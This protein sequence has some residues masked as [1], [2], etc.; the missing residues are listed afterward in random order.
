MSITI[1]TN[2]ASISA[3]FR[4]VIFESTSNRFDVNPRAYAISAVSSGTGGYA[5]YATVSPVVSVGD[6]VLGSAFT[7]L[8]VAYNVLQAVTVVNAAWFETNLLFVATA[9]G[10]GTMTRQNKNFQLRAET[11]VFPSTKIAIVSASAAAPSG[12]WLYLG[13]VTTAAFTVGQ[14]VMIEDTGTVN[15]DSF[16]KVVELNSNSVRIATSFTANVTGSIRI[17]ALVGTKRISSLIKSTTFRLNCAGHLASSL[18]HDLIDNAPANIQT[19][20]GNSLKTYTIRLVEE[21]DDRFG[22]LQEFDSVYSVKRFAS[23]S[24]WQ[25]NETQSMAP[26]LTIGATKKFLTKAPLIKSIRVGEE[27]QL[28]FINQ[29]SVTI[30]NPEF[31][32]NSKAWD[33]SGVASYNSNDIRLGDGISSGFVEQ[34]DVFIDYTTQHV[35][36]NITAIVGTV[37]VSFGTSAIQTI[38]GTGTYLISG[39]PTSNLKLQIAVAAGS[40]ATIES[41]YPTNERYIVNVQKYDLGGNALTLVTF[42]NVETVDCKGIIPI[43]SNMFDATISKFEVWLTDLATTFF[44]AVQKT[45]KRTFIVDRSNYQNPVRMHFENSLG[46]SDA[47]TFTGDYKKASKTKRTSFKKSLALGFAIRDRGTTDLGSSSDV[48]FEVYSPLL[49]NAEA[50]W[51]FELTSSSSVFT[52]AIGQ[53]VFTPINIFTESQIIAD[54]TQPPQLKVV[55]A[56]SNEPLGLNN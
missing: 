15:Y 10:A 6:T 56:E 52:K 40:Q 18:S 5:R 34:K 27:E 24:V 20:A 55:Y 43:N 47:Y 13:A 33:L 4:P 19:P 42:A 53:T 22:L 38:T 9:T 29:K 45:E 41:V 7:G 30:V 49:S 14:T 8:S 44:P 3:A 2:P 51:L 28:S 54:S 12:T 35:T 39:I 37:T 25:H 16:Q 50:Q 48:A 17:G 46:G 36:V 1:N 23:R 11:H 32:G 26:Y 31:T 21:F